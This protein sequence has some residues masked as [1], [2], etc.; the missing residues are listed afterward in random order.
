MSLKAQLIWAALLGL[1][2]LLSAAIAFQDMAATLGSEFS[3]LSGTE[4]AWLA[5]V[6]RFSSEASGRNLARSNP[7]RQFLAAYSDCTGIEAGYSYFAPTVPGNCRLAF[8]LHY[9]DGRVEYDVPVVSGASAGDRVS[10]LLDQLRF[11]RYLRLR[12]ALLQSLVNSIHREHPDAVWIRAVL[13]TAELT[14]PAEFRA[15]KRTFYQPLFA[16][17]FRYRSDSQSAADR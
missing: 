1:H 6:A 4:R 7:V 16:Y 2:L 17:D 3:Q 12:E 10:T 14:T 8:E 13:G 11:V 9:P 15:G 5:R